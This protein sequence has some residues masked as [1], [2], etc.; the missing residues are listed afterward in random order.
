[1]S[2]REFL[3]KSSTYNVYKIAANNICISICSPSCVCV[4]CYEKQEV[5][6]SIISLLYITFSSDTVLLLAPQN[7]I[8][9][10]ITTRSS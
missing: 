9:G 7:F 8:Q 5:E 1:M 10:S 4:S 2:A 6:N 3:D